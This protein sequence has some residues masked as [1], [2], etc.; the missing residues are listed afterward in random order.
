MHYSPCHLYQRDRARELGQPILNVACKEDPANL[1]GDFNATNIDIEDYDVEMRVDL[2]S[3]VR[4]FQKMSAL[5]MDFPDATFAHVILGEFLEHCTEEAA[6][7]SLEETCQI[8]RG[9]SVRRL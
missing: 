8:S 2:Y 1:G 7:R 6:R 5:H 3:A 4:N 9:D